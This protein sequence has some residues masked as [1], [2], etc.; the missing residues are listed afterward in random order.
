HY[1]SI[2]QQN[3]DNPLIL[4]NYA[5]YLNSNRDLRGAEEY[6]SRAVL[7][8]PGDG[9]ILSEFAKW[10]WELHGDKERAEGYF[11][12]GVQAASQDRY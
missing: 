4:R 3:P 7:A 11:Q 10:I 8:D 5:Q 6:Y 2:L 9:E 12:R 1:R